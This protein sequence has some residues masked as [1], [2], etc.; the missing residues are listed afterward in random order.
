MSSWTKQ[1]S[2]AARAQGWDVFEIWDG[3][4]ARITLEVQRPFAVDTF[5][6]DEAARAYVRVRAS[7][8]PNKDALCHKAW[9]LVFKSKL[10]ASSAPKKGKKK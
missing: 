8:T 4:T 6:D 5:A 9:A 7:D 1:D 2:T 3:G 10:G